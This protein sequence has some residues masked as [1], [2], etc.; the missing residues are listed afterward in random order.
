MTDSVA[1]VKPSQAKPSVC[2]HGEEKQSK[3]KQS[4]ARS[5]QTLLFVLFFTLTPIF[6][7]KITCD[8]LNKLF[9]TL[10][11]CLFII[12]FNFTF[13]FNSI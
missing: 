4:K 5:A 7:R 12:H 9:N 3:A 6:I 1:P 10:L 11:F 8:F 2:M 13:T